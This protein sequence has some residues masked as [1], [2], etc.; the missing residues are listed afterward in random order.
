MG[1]RG[2]ARLRREGGGAGRFHGNR[3]EAR[4]AVGGAQVG[5]L[6]VGCANPEA[7]P[8]GSLAGP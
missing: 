8:P 6:R 2:A 1:G 4:G 3:A 7:G 5:T